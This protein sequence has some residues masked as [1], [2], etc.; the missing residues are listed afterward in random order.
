MSDRKNKG[1]LCLRPVPDLQ[2]LVLDRCDGRRLVSEAKT[3]F[4]ALISSDFVEWNADG[5]SPETPETRFGVDD[6]VAKATFPKILTGSSFFTPNQFIK[7]NETHPDILSRDGATFFPIE[8]D[9]NRF[10][11]VVHIVWGRLTA[12]VYRFSPS[13]DLIWD[14]EE[15]DCRVVRPR[16]L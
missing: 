3:T 11:G 10:V 2:D 6:L 16:V 15:R 13:D 1:L 5:P 9:G 8:V 12:H 7:V 4:L 14:P